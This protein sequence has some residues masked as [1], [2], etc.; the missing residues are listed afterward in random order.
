V[1]VAEADNV[2]A[3]GPLRVSISEWGVFLADAGALKEGLS[4]AQRDHPL[5]QV[6][7]AAFRMLG[8]YEEIYLR[9]AQGNALRL[10]WLQENAFNSHLHL[11]SFDDARAS[12]A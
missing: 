7:G 2:D 5:Q 3:V 11:L 4:P 10:T 6:D 9:T 8:G 12:G 1:G